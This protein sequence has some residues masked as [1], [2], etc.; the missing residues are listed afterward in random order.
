MCFRLRT[1]YA[2]YVDEA[3]SGIEGIRRARASNVYDLIL[4]D[5]KMPKKTGVETYKDLTGIVGSNCKIVFMSAYSDSEEW[6][7]AIDMSVELV[8]K[9][10]SEQRLTEILR[11]TR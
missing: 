2:A 6:K 5:L 10:I 9:P 3:K 4:V 1:K 8:H 7:R 11:A